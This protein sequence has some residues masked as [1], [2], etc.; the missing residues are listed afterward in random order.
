MNNTTQHDTPLN[1]TRHYYMGTYSLGGH[2]WNAGEAYLEMA[3]KLADAGSL[4]FAG[5][6]IRQAEEAYTWANALQ[7]GSIVESL[8]DLLGVRI[9]SLDA[10]VA[11]ERVAILNSRVRGESLPSSP[12]NVSRETYSPKNVSRETFVT[13][14]PSVPTASAYDEVMETYTTPTATASDLVAQLISLIVRQVSAEMESIAEGVLE[15]HDLVDD[16]TESYAFSSA[17]D[18]AVDNYDISDK[19]REAL[20]EVTFTVSVD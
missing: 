6:F 12:S 11:P 8:E 1:T 2:L 9:D 5:Q 14:L 19:I 16:V 20:Q 10:W 18:S 3:E 13:P 7:A 15:G 4:E 17:V